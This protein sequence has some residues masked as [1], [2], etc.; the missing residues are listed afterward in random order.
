M[1]CESAVGFNWAYSTV[2]DGTACLFLENE[3]ACPKHFYKHYQ[4]K[5]IRILGLICKFVKKFFLWQT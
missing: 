1:D 5:K 2:L 4:V 3:V